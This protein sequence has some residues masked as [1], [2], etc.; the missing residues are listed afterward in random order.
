MKLIATFLYLIVQ[1]NLAY[2]VFNVCE[3]FKANDGS[4]NRS[5]VKLGGD[6]TRSWI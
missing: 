1:L 5:G 6:Y 2:V 3:A 4:S